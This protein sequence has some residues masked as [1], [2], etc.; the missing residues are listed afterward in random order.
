MIIKPRKYNKVRELIIGDETTGFCGH[1]C[2]W[3]R[4]QR[5][6]VTMVAVCME[7]KEMGE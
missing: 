7:G 6:S 4:G 3:E 1:V 5:V 2:Y